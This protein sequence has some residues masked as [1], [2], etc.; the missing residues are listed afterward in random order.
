MVTKPPT[1]S[2]MYIELRTSLEMFR[3]DL[4]DLEALANASR[5]A[6]DQLP[7]VPKEPKTDDGEA[8]PNPDPESALRTGRLDSLV[9]ATASAAQNALVTCVKLIDWAYEYEP[10]E[11]DDDDDMVP[12]DDIDD[13][14]D[15]DGGSS[16]ANGGGSNSSG[17][18]GPPDDDGAGATS[19]SVADELAK[20][21]PSRGGIV[22]DMP[23]RA[24]TAD[25]PVDAR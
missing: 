11:D 10:D 5:D 1:E 17:R 15:D 24:P 19:A 20:A 14:D 8:H 12:M 23:M 21:R 22:L 3:G 13:D 7:F 25:G 4:V 16:G 18:S 6:L 2:S 9:C